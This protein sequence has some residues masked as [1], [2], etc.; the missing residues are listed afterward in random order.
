MMADRR[1][2][3]C[4]K[5]RIQYPRH[6]TAVEKNFVRSPF[7]FR[8]QTK[9]ISSTVHFYFVRRRNLFHPQTEK[10]GCPL[11]RSLQKGFS[12]I[13]ANQAKSNRVVPINS[14]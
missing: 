9:K 12:G 11:Q 6:A 7:Q 1:I 8:P 3:T 5:V 2:G 13:L 14:L 10:A 4:G